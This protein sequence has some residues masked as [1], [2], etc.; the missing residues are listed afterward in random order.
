ML[1]NLDMMVY[2]LRLK[3]KSTTGVFCEILEQVLWR[4]L[5]GAASEKETVEEKDAQ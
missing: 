5:L 1:R 2:A 3:Q 4:I